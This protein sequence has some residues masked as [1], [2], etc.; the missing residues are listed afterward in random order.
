MPTK[1]S[2][3]GMSC[4]HCANAVA[5]ALSRVPGV[6]RVVEVSLER[7]VAIVEGEPD[8]AGLVAAVEA[9]GYAA[10]LE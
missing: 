5:K 4:G 2:V 8:P 10:T 1:L 7:G 6:A 9:E 3:R